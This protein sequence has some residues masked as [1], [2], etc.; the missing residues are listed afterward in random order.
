[1]PAFPHDEILLIL[2]S[3]GESRTI[4][5]VQ[6]SENPPREFLLFFAKISNSCSFQTLPGGFIALGLP[7]TPSSA[8]P[9]I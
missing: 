9:S 3:A 4:L 6:G 1:M 7:R 8:L 5:L 2:C